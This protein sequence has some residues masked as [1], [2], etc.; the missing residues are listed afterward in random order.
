M[1]LHFCF[2]EEALTPY[3][4]LLSGFIE[5]VKKALKKLGTTISMMPERQLVELEV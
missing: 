4:Q 5:L 1:E 2:G 3:P